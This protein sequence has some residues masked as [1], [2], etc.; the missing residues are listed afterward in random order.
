MWYYTESK[1]NFC[2]R[3][4]S[5]ILNVFL[6]QDESMY[7]LILADN[8]IEVIKSSNFLECAAFKYIT[9]PTTNVDHSKKNKIFETGVIQHPTKSY[10]FILF[11]L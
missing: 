4:T 5:P 9:N 10:F 6:S 2:P 7:F 3:L 1:K 11:V 8:S